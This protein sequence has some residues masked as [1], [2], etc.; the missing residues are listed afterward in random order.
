MDWKEWALGILV[1]AVSFFGGLF[2]KRNDSD[3][4]KLSVELEDFRKSARTSE[5]CMVLHHNIDEK[6][7]EL[8][9][10]QAEMKDTL[11]QIK[12]YMAREEGAREARGEGN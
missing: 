12:Q 5:M 3:I 9:K 7:N 10:T 4:K 8:K 2:I 6:L 11:D 1:V